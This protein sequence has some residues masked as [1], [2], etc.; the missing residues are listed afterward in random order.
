[1][2]KPSVECNNKIVTSE[3]VNDLLEQ[4]RQAY[5]QSVR[6]FGTTMQDHSPALVGVMIGRVS[7]FAEITSIIKSWGNNLEDV[8]KETT[9]KT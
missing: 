9:E 4:I 3:D 7:A 2:E 5:T 6:E 1:M 8:K